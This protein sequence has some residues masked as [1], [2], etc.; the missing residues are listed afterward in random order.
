MITGR[1]GTLGKVYFVP[2]DFWPLNTTLYVRDFKG[3]DPRFIAYFLSELDFSAYSD[4]AAVPGL[5]RNHLHEAPVRVPPLTEQRAIA[6]ILGT[7]DDKIEL[8]RRMNQSLEE[9]AQALFK[10]WFVD[11]DPVRAKMSG[12]WR[13]GQSL[14]GLPA[15][16]YHLFPNRLVPSELGRIPKGWQ[17]RPLG[18]MVTV[19]KGRSYRRHELAESDTALVTLRS[20]ARG[21]GYR[22]DGLKPF[23]GLYKLDQVVRAGEIV[24]ACTDLTQDAYVI[25][26]PAIVQST[27]EF[28][29]LVASLD[30]L[31]VRPSQ[32]AMSCSLLYL[33]AASDAFI[34]HTY[35][36]STGTTVLHLTKDAIPSFRFASPH[37]RLVKAFD[38]MAS[39]ALE[40]IRKSDRE[41]SALVNLRELLL[42]SLVSGRID[43]TDIARRV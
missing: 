22:A 20:F 9:M 25:G 4:K 38:T 23:T 12:R 43:L 27:D 33:L 17:V 10:S 34:A 1:Y 6:H 15:H 24:I 16:L 21:G 36:H 29:T 3:N 39:R 11:F 42:P 26:H 37:I 40:K 35:A 28:S 18:E 7:L 13:P 32:D 2:E 41:T 30:A 8:N 31:I 14:P 5:N 19:V